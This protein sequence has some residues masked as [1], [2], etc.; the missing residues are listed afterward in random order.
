MSLAKEQRIERL[1]KTMDFIAYGSLGLDIMISAITVL[2]MYHIGNPS[3]YLGPIN[4]LLT[5]VVAL[6]IL[7]AITIVTMIHY[8]HVYV[9]LTDIHVRVKNGFSKFT[10]SRYAYSPRKGLLEKIVDRFF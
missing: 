2:S 5:A 3:V 1:K 8:E 6:T 10:K 9:R 4:L 7:L